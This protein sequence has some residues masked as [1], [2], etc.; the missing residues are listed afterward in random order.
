[1]C[2]GRVSRGFEE[3]AAVMKLDKVRLDEAE[4][5]NAG[6]TKVLRT[7]C[8]DTAGVRLVFA[9]WIDRSS[10]CEQVR[11]SSVYV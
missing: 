8:A 11:Q 3:S 1:M 10:D 9:G 4:Q 5:T 2:G 7:R 6:R